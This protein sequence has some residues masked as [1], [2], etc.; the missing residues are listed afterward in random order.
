MGTLSRG[1]AAGAAGVT[2]LNAATY[3]DMLLTGRP[4]SEVPGRTI[5]GLLDGAGIEIPGRG[6]V[7]GHRR[8]ALAALGGISTGLVVGVAASAARR[9]G[10]RLPG[11]VG[12]VATGAAAM[13]AGDFAPMRLGLTDPQAWSA[14]DWASDVVPHLAYGVAVRTVLDRLDRLDRM[15]R[16]GPRKDVRR[17]DDLR[18][19][20]RTAL[21]RQR[22]VRRGDRGGLLVRSALLGVASGC[23]STVGLAGPVLAARGSS[24][25]TAKGLAVAGL[26]GGELVADKLPQTPS[27]LEAPG[28]LPRYGTGAVGAALLARRQESGVALPVAAA[29]AGTA[30]GSAGGAWWRE[31]AAQRGWS[32]GAA[33]AEDAVALGLTTVA[34]RPRR[35]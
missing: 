35:R 6:R 22:R 29:A 18:R 10:L 8:S 27:R 14:R 16:T 32:H 23:R 31:Y 4:E 25:R 34:C 12:A 17:A 30:L 20:Q 3:L 11:P 21:R 33:L 13:V 19:A 24:H 5:Q 26:V 15:D 1:L 2:A 9:A 7:A 28:L